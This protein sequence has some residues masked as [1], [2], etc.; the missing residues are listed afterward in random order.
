MLFVY[1]WHFEKVR[2][3]KQRMCADSDR[4]FPGADEISISLIGAFARFDLT[5]SMF[6]TD[7]IRSHE[8]RCRVSRF[9]L[10]ST[11]VA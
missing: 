2:N 11:S 9:T 3:L 5:H 4:V 1:F 7:V 10:L 6:R 8:P